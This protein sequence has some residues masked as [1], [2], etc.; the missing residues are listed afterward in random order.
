MTE[1]MRNTD[2]KISLDGKRI[3]GRRR[4]GEAGSALVA[5]LCL[6]FLGGMLA[7]A[8]AGMTLISTLDM[9]A[10]TE[11]Q[12]SFYINEGVLNRVSFLISADRDQNGRNPVLGDVD[13]E[14]YEYDR[15]L[16]DGVLHEVD[17]Y[18][19]KVLVTVYDAISGWDLSS[20]SNRYRNTLRTFTSDLDTEQ[21]VIDAVN[22]L[23]VRIADYI[24]TDDTV[25]TGTVS[26]T[27]S[28]EG[29]EKDDY[30]S[31][32]MRPL[33][34]NGAMQYREELYYIK[35]LT[36][37]FPPDRFGRLSSIR[38]IP[39]SGTVILNGTPSFFSAPPEM[40]SLLGDL[41]DDELAAV[42]AAREKLRKERIQISD[43]LDTGVAA[44]LQRNM[45]WTSSNYYTVV[46]GPSPRSRR[47]SKRLSASF[48]ALEIS[49]A[50]GEV[51]EYLEWVSY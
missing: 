42:L 4:S 43:E 11:I 48:G 16:Q 37:F 18:G 19:Y 34:R 1:N 5:V 40:I 33:P 6:V 17:Y 38:L 25:A 39:P 44:K 14:E 36:D 13:Y 2:G 46:I 31:E 10:H 41:E 28:A 7:A 32:G 50:S 45:S 35:G 30:E 20:D 47:P 29:M 8:V 24:D 12:R 26:G 49:G 51:Q 22:D 21:D 9:A 3:A 23:A 15:F 27:D